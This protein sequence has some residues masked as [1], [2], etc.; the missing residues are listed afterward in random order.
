MSGPKVGADAPD[1]T[2]ITSPILI[3]VPV[4]A[5]TYAVLAN[6]LSHKPPSLMLATPAITPPPTLTLHTKLPLPMITPLSCT[7][8]KDVTL[9]PDKLGDYTRLSS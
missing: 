9:I 8:L 2:P 1:L 4:R 6:E 5:Q 3:S 7:M